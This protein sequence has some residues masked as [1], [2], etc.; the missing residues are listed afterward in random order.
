MSVKNAIF[1]HQRVYLNPESIWAQEPNQKAKVEIAAFGRL[2]NPNNL[3][4][5]EI[6][7]E[8]DTSQEDARRLEKSLNGAVPPLIFLHSLRW[9]KSK[10]FGELPI[11]RLDELTNYQPLFDK[12]HHVAIVYISDL[13]SVDPKFVEEEEHICSTWKRGWEMLQQEPSE[14]DSPYGFR[15]PNWKNYISKQYTIIH[16]GADQSELTLLQKAALKIICSESLPP[17]EPLFNK[18][19]TMLG[20][21]KLF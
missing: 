21:P 16:I 12:V 11:G 13:N 19:L 18:F 4:W 15:N 20:L 8:Q 9:E 5:F 2:F 17:A 3:P 10:G 1:A 6:N 14:W 7:V